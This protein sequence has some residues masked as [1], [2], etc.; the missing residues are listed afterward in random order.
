[1]A[2]DTLLKW[3]KNELVFVIVVLVSVFTVSRI[4]LITGQM[5]ARD[6]QRKADVELVGRALLSYYADYETYPAA[7]ESGKIALCG[8]RASQ[9]CEWGQGG[10]VDE[11]GVT[12]LKNLPQEPLSD[13]GRKYVYVPSLARDHFRIY[14]A[15]EHKKDKGIRPDL[16]VECGRDVQCNWYVEY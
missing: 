8:F 9:A 1:M 3:P 6:A 14:I 15:L 7:S 5:K 13:S 16:T 4:Q 11:E 2:S 12:Y 10:L